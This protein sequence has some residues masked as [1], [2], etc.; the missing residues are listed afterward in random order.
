MP[1]LCQVL[2]IVILECR[3][4]VRRSCAVR[5]QPRAKIP[6][7]DA[8][9]VLDHLGLV[10]KP[11]LMRI[12]SSHSGHARRRSR[13][14]RR[15]TPPPRPP[16]FLGISSQRPCCSPH[17]FSPPLVTGCPTLVPSHT[18]PAFRVHSRC[19]HLPGIPSVLYLANDRSIPDD[20]ELVGW[21]S[22]TRIQRTRR[23][24]TQRERR[25]DH[26]PTSSPLVPKL[27]ARCSTTPT[28]F[29][30]VKDSF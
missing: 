24:P 22:T 21:P 3:L 7:H 13:Q 5:A 12:G 16:R 6:R 4:C 18:P 29:G 10:R 28:S 25:Q 30:V 2:N 23:N 9:A 17:D 19:K 20:S 11:P 8:R 26:R 14:D 27:L 15:P 1:K